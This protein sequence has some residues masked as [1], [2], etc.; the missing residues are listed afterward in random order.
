MDLGPDQ[1]R[2][3][4]N[5]R[6]RLGEPFPRARLG[7]SFSVKYAHHACW[8]QSEVVWTSPTS[9]STAI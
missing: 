3:G 4:L 1:L 8:T 5:G 9:T 2:D 7:E 6:A